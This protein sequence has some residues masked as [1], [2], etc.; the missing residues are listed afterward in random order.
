MKRMPRKYTTF[1]G[2]SILLFTLETAHLLEY[3]K[4]YFISFL[5]AQGRSDLN[6]LEH[7]YIDIVFGLAKVG[8]AVAAGIL[9]NQHNI[10]VAF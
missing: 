3:L 6:Y 5:T 9:H 8:S 10:E 1:L 7:N 4:P 2:G